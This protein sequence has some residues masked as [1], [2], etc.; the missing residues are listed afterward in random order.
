MLC[1]SSPGNI[2][3]WQCIH[4]STH[5]PDTFTSRFNKH[6]SS[7]TAVGSFRCRKTQLLVESRLL[8]QHQAIFLS[9]SIE[10]RGVLVGYPCHSLGYR[11]FIETYIPRYDTQEHSYRADRCCPWVPTNNREQPRTTVSYSGV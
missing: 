7:S 3:G 5:H 8:Q 9:L 4:T 2:G 11:E 1:T 6:Y 10:G